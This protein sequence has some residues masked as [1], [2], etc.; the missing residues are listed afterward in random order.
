MKGKMKQ[1]GIEEGD[2]EDD[3]GRK[4]EHGYEVGGGRIYT[5]DN[6]RGDK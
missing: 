2:V 5:R 6:T 3:A 4:K 1:V